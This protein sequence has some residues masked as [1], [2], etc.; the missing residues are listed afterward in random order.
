MYPEVPR[1]LGKLADSS[2]HGRVVHSLFIP[3]AVLSRLT[4]RT[5]SRTFLHPVARKRKENTDGIPLGW[6]ESTFERTSQLSPATLLLPVPLLRINRVPARLP[7]RRND[8]FRSRSHLLVLVSR[9]NCH[10]RS[11]KNPGC[12][13]TGLSHYLCTLRVFL[14]PSSPLPS[15]HHNRG[16][17]IKSAF[18]LIHSSQQSS[19]LLSVS[20]LPSYSFLVCLFFGARNR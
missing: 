8:K 18:A 2:S 14:S 11:V 3:R 17:I 1:W 16:E 15:S 6:M 9:L 13:S 4:T 12:V 7:L 19:P 10:N 5:L 20:K